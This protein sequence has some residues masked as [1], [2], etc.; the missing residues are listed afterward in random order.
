MPRM[1]HQ[2]LRYL[3][4]MPKPPNYY[5]PFDPREVPAHPSPRMKK[6]ISALY[7]ASVEVHRTLYRIM[8][9]REIT[10]NRVF[11]G[12]VTRSAAIRPMLTVRG[13]LSFVVAMSIC[14][15]FDLKDTTASLRRV[16]RTLTDRREEVC[17]RRL[18]EEANTNIDIDKALAR[19]RRL[20]QRLNSGEISDA[21]ARLK[22]LRD[23]ELAHL[24]IE[25][26]FA[27]GK[28]KFGDM[29]RTFVFA[30]NVV[31]AATVVAVKR[32]LDTRG[33][34]EDARQQACSFTDVLIR[35]AVEGEQHR[36]AYS[37]VANCGCR[38]ISPGVRADK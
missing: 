33:S 16:L 30:V 15:V 38:R 29:Y 32:L 11:I 7:F 9:L 2:K 5:P 26:E 24:D 20:S 23:K 37:S 27:R 8:L 31:N 22:D 6:A 1:F 36:A 10:S 18:H 28:P 17:L 19:L 35:G 25:A 13:G 3:D 34:Y 14:S 12:R 21:L 4:E